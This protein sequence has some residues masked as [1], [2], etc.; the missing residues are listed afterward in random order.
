MQLCLK[1]GANYFTL[2]FRCVQTEEGELLTMDST[3]DTLLG[4]WNA[5]PL[6]QQLPFLSVTDVPSSCRLGY[7][8]DIFSEL[9]TGRRADTDADSLS[10][11]SS[12]PPET[13]RKLAR[14]TL[15]H[16]LLDD[17]FEVLHHAQEMLT[18][19]EAQQP[20]GKRG[21]GSK[22]APPSESRPSPSPPSPSGWCRRSVGSQSSSGAPTG[23][24]AT[25][26]CRTATR[27]SACAARCAHACSHP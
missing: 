12:L 15:R 16:D 23:A 9:R 4:L 2:L 7:S 18:A 3:P 10:P 20:K 24:R 26:G 19:L 11:S 17:S 25:A 8:V 1:S 27:R 5:D 13:L 22:S 6:L 14:T 21:G